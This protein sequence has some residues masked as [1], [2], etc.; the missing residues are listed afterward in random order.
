MAYRPPKKTERQKKEEELQAAQTPEGK[1]P[2]GDDRNLVVV[3]EDFSEAEFEDRMWL[4]WQRNKAFIV[5]TVVACFAVVIGVQGFRHFQSE[6]RKA[7]QDS[8]L[9]ADSTE[10]KAAFGQENAGNPLGGLALLQ[11]AD[12]IYAEEDYA[13]AAEQ[14]LAAA[15]AFEEPIFKY[16]AQLGAA[17]ATL[18]AGD[19][20][21][22]AS[23]LAA[24]SGETSAPEAVRAEAAY[25][26]AALDIASGSFETAYETLSSIETRGWQQMAEQLIAEVPELRALR[27]QESLETET[28]VT[29]E[30]E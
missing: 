28:T 11:A 4:Y 30:E 12:A 1:A 26:L 17:M 19:Q 23:Q 21:A 18:K 27:E 9:A 7:M 20:E 15:K 22:G 16:R 29:A 5:G 14:Y 24:L 3:D 10:A 8:Y 2:Q 6:G 13:A 25:H